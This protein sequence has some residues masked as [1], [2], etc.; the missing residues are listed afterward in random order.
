MLW[1]DDMIAL[2]IDT[3]SF[4]DF[5]KWYIMVGTKN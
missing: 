2:W 3:A 4:F 1:L 5:K